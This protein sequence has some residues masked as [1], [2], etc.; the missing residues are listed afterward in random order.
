MVGQK[1]PPGADIARISIVHCQGDI[2]VG[3][4]E[5]TVLQK[6]RGPH[7]VMRALFRRT[8]SRLIVPKLPR[9]NCSDFTPVSPS[10]WSP[11]IEL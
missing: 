6:V 10:E 2:S 7:N 9:T 1:R 3:G 8:S 4:F 5:D 11:Q